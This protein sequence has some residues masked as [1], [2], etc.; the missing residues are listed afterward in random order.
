LI[1]SFDSAFDSLDR[2]SLEPHQSL[3][4]VGQRDCILPAGERPLLES[5]KSIDLDGNK[6]FPSDTIHADFFDWAV[7]EINR[8][9]I[10]LSRNG[11]LRR[12][13]NQVLMVRTARSRLI[14]DFDV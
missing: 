7:L 8:E 3:F 12:N 9:R 1:R 10:D 11:M 5:A 4:E 2:S 6:R 14:Q 13:Q